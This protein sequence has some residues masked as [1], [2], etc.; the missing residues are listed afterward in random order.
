MIWKMIVKV[1]ETGE[2]IEGVLCEG[3]YFDKK[4][5]EA[6]WRRYPIDQIEIIDLLNEDETENE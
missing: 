1:K 4:I 5:N 3:K 2:L 6:V